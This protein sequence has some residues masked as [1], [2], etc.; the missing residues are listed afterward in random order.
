MQFR[1]KNIPVPEAHIFGFILGVLLQL[2]FKTKLFSSA[3]IGRFIGWPLIILGIC[4]SAWAVIE[5]GEMDISSPEMLITSGPYAFSR[6]P[7]Y[8]G[9]SL[10]YLGVTFALNSNWL[11]AFFL[12]V[13][14]YIHIWEIPKEERTLEQKIGARY[15]EYRDQ[16]RRYL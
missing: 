7:M 11:L 4:L 6:N 10:L 2:L 14:V 1:L 5:A 3:R 9:W 16:V 15:R 13:I 12:P 8:V